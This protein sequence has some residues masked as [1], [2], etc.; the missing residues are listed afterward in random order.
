MKKRMELAS[1]ATAQ[2]LNNAVFGMAGPV[3]S[4]S[5]YLG[6]T[7]NRAGECLLE[8][9]LPHGYEKTIFPYSDLESA[10]RPLVTSVN[11]AD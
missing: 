1:K 4:L 2:W 10:S 9:V 11:L 6:A 8:D 3:K 5:G 7:G